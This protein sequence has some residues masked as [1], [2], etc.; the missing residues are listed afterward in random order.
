[1]MQ[2]WGLVTSQPTL[3]AVSSGEELLRLRQDV[4][5]IYV[6][7]EISKYILSLV[8]T[9]RMMA[10]RTDNPAAR[11]NLN[12]GASP[13]ASLALFQAGR[14]L[15]WLRGEDFVSPA[16]LQDLAPDILRHR[17]GLTYEA[18]AEEITTD[19]IIGQILER[20]PVPAVVKS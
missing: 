8:R 13:R 19:K 16:L 7:P 15:A 11:R 14:A 9:T 1:M 20:T 10:E 2:R 4:D 12:F 17:L 6:A 3:V 18:E 5:R